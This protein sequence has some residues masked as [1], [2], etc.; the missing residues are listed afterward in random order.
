[1]GLYGLMFSESNDP[2]IILREYQLIAVDE[3]ENYL[4]ENKGGRALLVAPTGSGK[5]VLAAEIIRR[6]VEKGGMV[7][8]IGHRRELIHQFSNTLRD[9]GVE[10][11]FIMAGER[12]SLFPDV[13]LASIQ[14]LSSR[15]KRGVISLPP[16]TLL[17]VDE[18]HHIN[19]KT[20]Q[21]VINHYQGIPIIGLTATPIRGDGKGLGIPE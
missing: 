19:A 5:T 20:Y 3:I 16:A 18:A 17:I 15:L 2:E 13:Q 6:K 4:A 11:A 8:V 9:I 21:D 10:H 14:T 1:M 7:L 12:K